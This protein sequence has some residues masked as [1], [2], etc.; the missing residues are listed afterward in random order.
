MWSDTKPKQK[1]F[2][3]LLGYFLPDV[4]LLNITFGSELLAVSEAIAKGIG[5]EE[6]IFPNGSKAIALQVPFSPPYVEEKVCIFLL[7]YEAVVLFTLS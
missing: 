7:V 2:E 6:Q 4:V 5:L 3:A 1:V